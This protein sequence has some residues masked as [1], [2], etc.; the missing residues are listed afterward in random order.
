MAYW[1]CVG[2]VVLMANLNAL[3]DL[4][5]H[6]SE[7]YLD[8]E[9]LVVGGSSAAVTAALCLVLKVQAR[10]RSQNLELQNKDL[11]ARLDS[12]AEGLRA[13]NER[14][15]SEIRE[16]AA[17]QRAVADSEEKYRSLVESTDDSIYVVDS[18]Y[19]YLFANAR[20][21]VRLGHPDGVAGHPYGDFH[22]EEETLNFTAL[23]DRVLA[24]GES[25]QHEQ[26]SRRDGRTFLWTLS[27]V[28]GP[29]G[30]A[31]A[32]TVVSKDITEK[33]Q[34]EEAFREQSITDELTGLHN[35][36]GFLAL[37]EQGFKMARRMGKGVSLFYADL[38]DLKKINDSLGHSE[39]DRALQAA[40]R[41]L[42][43]CCRDSDILARIG[44]DEFVVL[45]FEDSEAGPDL[46]A[47]RLKD[48]LAHQDPADAVEGLSFS[49]GWASCSPQVF[50]RKPGCP[51]DP[52]TVAQLLVRADQ[53]MY[54]QKRARK[55]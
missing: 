8:V 42:R 11:S 35:R 6:P 38:D 40:A 50:C 12:E 27:P 10:L 33:K 16:R 48:R 49:T 31:A 14:L 54:E 45:Q 47:A 39:G 5:L 24:S 2:A 18:G 34:M 43:A 53:A 15:A 3:M 52:C 13:A 9:H 28:R 7:P 41:A 26:K 30:T 37:A 44:G 25:I 32:V 36:R 1:A 17:S 23:V 51:E 55:A 21:A 29:E 22:T 20:H 19:R 4:V 46:L